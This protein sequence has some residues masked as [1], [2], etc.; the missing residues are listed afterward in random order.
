MRLHLYVDSIPA[1]NSVLHVMILEIQATY[2]TMQ[3]LHYSLVYTGPPVA[4]LLVHPQ[5]C[6]SNTARTIAIA[7]AQTYYTYKHAHV[8]KAI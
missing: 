4:W 1:V 6:T 5:F 3:S 2:A 7:S 8:I